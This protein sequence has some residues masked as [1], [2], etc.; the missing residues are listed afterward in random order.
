MQIGKKLQT[1][2][3]QFSACLLRQTYHI[4]RKCSFFN[5]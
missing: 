1:F 4:E 3:I 2:Y 5:I